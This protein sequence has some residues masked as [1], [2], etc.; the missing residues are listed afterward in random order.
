MTDTTRLEALEAL[1]EKVKAG[2]AFQIDAPQR[3]GR[4]PEY[5]CLGG[6]YQDNMAYGAFHGSTDAAIEFVK[7]VLPEGST[8]QYY[9]GDGH[10]IVGYGPGAADY[11]EAHD[12][13]PAR[14]LLI[15]GIEALIA[16]E[17][18]T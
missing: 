13:N 18:D 5:P 15:A 10:C 12:Q 8:W 17:R 3:K 14:A 6:Y 16:Q 7:A 9:S 1:L 11:S 2:S 4:T